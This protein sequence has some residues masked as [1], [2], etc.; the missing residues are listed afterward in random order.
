M[1]ELDPPITSTSE[2]YW[3]GTRRKQ[4]I[5]Q[6]CDS[7]SAWVHYPRPRCPRC[8]GTALSWRQPPADYRLYSW[9]LHRAVGDSPP[10]M[11]ALVEIDEGLRVLAELVGTFEGIDVD[12]PLEL[13]WR[14]L[15]D[16]RHLPDFRL[17]RAASPQEQ[18]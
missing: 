16:G 8:F 13:S 10:R 1:S 12:Q 2:E 18:S 9:A 5:F 11:V 15:A 3:E 17:T 4:L 14:P 7:C 6:W